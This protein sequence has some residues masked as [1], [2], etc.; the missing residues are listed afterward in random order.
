MHRLRIILEVAAKGVQSGFKAA[1]GAVKS[2]LGSL[3]G[4]AGSGRRFIDGLAQSVFFLGNAFRMVEDLARGLFDKF[5]GGARDVAR[6]ATRF[7]HLTGSEAAAAAVMDEV[8]KVAL[9]TGKDILEVGEAYALI[10]VN[11]RDASGAFDPT[12]LTETADLLQFL[13]GLRPELPLTMI[14]RGINALLATG[15]VTSLEMI[16]DMPIR[17]MLV[18][19]GIL[20]DVA[21]DIQSTQQEIGKAATFIEVGAA[22]ATGAAA[23]EMKLSAKAVKEAV[24][25]FTGI[26]AAEMIEDMAER[27][28]ME[29]LT[30]I[31]DDLAN[32][33]GGPL[34]EALNKFAGTIADMY[35]QDPEKF[36]EIAETLGDLAAVGLETLLEPLVEGLQSPEFLEGIEKVTEFLKLLQAGKIDAAFELVGLEDLQEGFESIV[37]SLE[38]IATVLMSVAKAMGVGAGMALGKEP[39]RTKD[40]TEAAGAAA[41]SLIPGGITPTE[42]VW[43][44]GWDALLDPLGAK[45]TE[46]A[47]E[48]NKILRSLLGKTQKIQVEI[49]LNSDM[50]EAQVKQGAED[51]VVRAFDEVHQ[52]YKRRGR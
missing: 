31:A 18:Q 15:Q 34:F 38:D 35:E 40:F 6:L 52:N 16:M 4:M 20:S 13:A 14:Q 1:S 33:L 25:A 17:A 2:F 8:R 3:A 23:D 36:R 47:R 19:A 11:A 43:E 42:M 37:Q 29:R 45:A 7:K 48:I 32:V 10:A 50:L 30:V 12:A 49:N 51:T 39:V 27:S 22:G 5:V 46:S 44:S 9:A 24:E 21:E 26:T 41:A 28:G